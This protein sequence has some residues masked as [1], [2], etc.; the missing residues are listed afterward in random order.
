M[1]FEQTYFEF[2]IHNRVFYYSI[3]VE[4]TDPAWLGQY[5]LFSHWLF[6]VWQ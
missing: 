2:E 1:F 3:G 5:N 6:K 4:R